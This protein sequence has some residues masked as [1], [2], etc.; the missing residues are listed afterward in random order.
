MSSRDIRV[1][2]VFFRVLY[3]N[4]LL[5]THKTL[6]PKKKK[7][8]RLIFSISH[9]NFSYSSSFPSF[10]FTFFT[11]QSPNLTHSHTL[12]LTLTVTDKC[13]S[14]FVKND[15]PP[16]PYR[17]CV[18]CSLLSRLFG[19]FYYLSLSSLRYVILP[20]N[21]YNNGDIF[22]DFFLGYSLKWVIGIGR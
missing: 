5:Q 11:S 3:K 7:P 10:N 4:L 9:N 17:R 13:T 15:V 19:C 2:L 8:I 1:N 22:F 14:S 6:Y 16:H 12:P 20:V 21:D 18:I